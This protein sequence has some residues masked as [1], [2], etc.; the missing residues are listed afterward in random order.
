[1]TPDPDQPYSAHVWAFMEDKASTMARTLRGETV[2]RFMPL[3][4]GMELQMTLNDD[5]QV[6]EARWVKVR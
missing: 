4:D 5:G 1:M 6:I 3:V 2:Q